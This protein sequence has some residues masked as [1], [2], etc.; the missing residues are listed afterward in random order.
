MTGPPKSIA[1]M[2]TRPARTVS[3]ALSSRWTRIPRSIKGSDPLAPNDSIVTAMMRSAMKPQTLLC[4]AL[5]LIGDL[6]AYG[7][8]VESLGNLNRQRNVG[9]MMLFDALNDGAT[10]CVCKVVSITPSPSSSVGYARGKVTLSVSEMIGGS[11]RSELSLPF[12]YTPVGRAGSRLIWPDLVESRNDSLLCVV[13]PHS[14]DPSTPAYADIT[15][16]AQSVI[17]LK[18][19]QTH[20]EWAFREIWRI[21]HE[22]DA[23]TLGNSLKQ[24]IDGANEWLNVYAAQSIAGNCHQKSPA[25]AEDLTAYLVSNYNRT[26]TVLL[27]R[28]LEI[29][30][31]YYIRHDMEEANGRPSMFHQLIVMLTAQSDDIQK[32]ALVVIAFHANPGELKKILSIPDQSILDHALAHDAGIAPYEVSKIKSNF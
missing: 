9:G 7:G 5:V 22:T 17:P 30:S 18:A 6:F 27:E 25:L 32:H 4:L 21:H 20:A 10:V 3:M 15:E 24:A 1:T 31:M 16:A 2:R 14:V 19:D 12:C 11:A 8:N 28:D 29:I 26:K 23:S 13:V